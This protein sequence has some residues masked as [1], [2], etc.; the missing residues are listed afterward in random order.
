MP[1][2][3]PNGI[4]NAKNDELVDAA[5]NGSSVAMG[6]LLQSCRAYLLAI[7]ESELTADLRIKVSP[8][9]LVQETSAQAQRSMPTFRGQTQKEFR[10]WVR[11]I[12]MN[13]LAQAR[14]KFKGTEGRDIGREERQ[15]NSSSILDLANRVL[16]NETPSQMAIR[17]EDQASLREAM[18]RLPED[19]RQVIRLRNFELVSFPEIGRTLGRTEEAMRKLWLRAM[20]RL[21]EELHSHDSS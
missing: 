13:R 6:E 8:S 7:G 11:G 5:R 15:L 9:D 17:K 2:S 10:M 3:S 4:P 12:F 1:S 14:R 18:A 21:K 20:K 19:Y 16:D